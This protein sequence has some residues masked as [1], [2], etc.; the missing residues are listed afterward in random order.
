MQETLCPLQACESYVLV[1]T[2]RRFAA[3]KFNLRWVPHILD[4]NQRAQRVELSSELLEVLTS[5]GRNKF[6]HAI[7]GDELW[8]YF[9]CPHAAV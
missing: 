1:Y 6:H 3:K 8:F 7:T 9:E 4:S 2:A 5:Q